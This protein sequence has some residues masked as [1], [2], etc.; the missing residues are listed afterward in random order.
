MPWAFRGHA[1]RTWSLLPTA[2][3]SG[4][5]II[6]C[7]RVEAVKRFEPLNTTPIL[8]WFLPPN[9][10][11]NGTKFGENDSHLARQLCIEAIAEILPIW[12]FVLRCDELG[13]PSLFGVVPVDSIPGNYWMFNGRYPLIDDDFF[14]FSNSGPGFALA[15]HHGIPTRLL[16]WTFNPLAAAFFAIEELEAR[17][18]EDIVIWAI[19]RQ[20]A[21]T[22][23]IE[24]VVFHYPGVGGTPPRINPYIEIIRPPRDENPY[25]AAQSGLFTTI[26]RSGIY[27]VKSGGRRPSLEDFVVE[28]NPD[29]IVLRKILLEHSHVADLR[30]ILDR[31]RVSRATFM[32]T[33]DHIAADV[34]RLWSA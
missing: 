23:S 29:K 10:Y 3:R 6:E 31:E 2:W 30:N 34:L 25:L 32:P 19:H 8:E 5:P 4:N 33:Y 7:A 28:A 24:G 26:R 11:S 27:Y 9:H 13:L 12:D 18:D 21:A 22:T 1:S 17:P 14:R 20:R 15:Q 16:D